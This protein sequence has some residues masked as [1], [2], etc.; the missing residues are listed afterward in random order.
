[1]APRCPLKEQSRAASASLVVNGER[2]AA[3]PASTFAD[4]LMRHLVIQPV[5]NVR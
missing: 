4:K 2:P 3:H 5:S 1:M